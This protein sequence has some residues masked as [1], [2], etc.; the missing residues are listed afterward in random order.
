MN[1]KTIV[2]VVFGLWSLICWRW[3]VCGIKQACGDRAMAN[4]AENT[5]TPAIEDMDTVAQYIPPTDQETP[6]PTTSANNAAKPQTGGNS[7]TAA[8]SHSSDRTINALDVVNVEELSNRMIIHFPYNSTRPEDRDA[9]GAYLDKL[10]AQLNAS[11]GK[12]TITGH[13]DFVG[14]AASNKRFGLLRAQGVRDLLVKKGV[15]ANNISCK[16]KG[17]ASPMASNDTPKGR[18]LNRRVE[19]RYNE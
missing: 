4:A 2:F 10:A 17:D 12:V 8:P 3:Y 15:P 9:M 7:G 1:S 19:I 5:I 13:T 6:S 11:G 16:S 14:D 18:Y